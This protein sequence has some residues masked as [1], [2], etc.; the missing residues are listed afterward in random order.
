M[1]YV[2]VDVKNFYVI[3]TLQYDYS[4]LYSLCTS[5]LFFNIFFYFLVKIEKGSGTKNCFSHEEYVFLV[6]NWFGS[7]GP[8]KKLFH[9]VDDCS[10]L[11]MR[12][13]SFILFDDDKNWKQPNP[14]VYW[15]NQIY[16]MER[17]IK[18]MEGK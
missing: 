13:E 12:R 2:G 8:G 15:K 10:Q 5:Y 1:E 14:E 9:F 4:I 7:Y 17:N 6:V 18:N 16:Q 11:S 3:Y